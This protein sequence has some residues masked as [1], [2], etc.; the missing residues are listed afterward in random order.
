MMLEV[1][2]VVAFG[3][4]GSDEVGHEEDLGCCNV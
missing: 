4:G 1:R 3:G 2:I